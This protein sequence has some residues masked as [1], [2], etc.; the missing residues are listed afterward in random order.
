MKTLSLDRELM[1]VRLFFE[2][3]NQETLFN[4]VNII[5]SNNLFLDEVI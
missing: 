3:Y 4:E 1:S 5:N 2:I